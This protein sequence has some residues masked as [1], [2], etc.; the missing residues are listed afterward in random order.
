[1]NYAVLSIMNACIFICGL[2]ISIICKTAEKFCDKISRQISTAI[3]GGS[4]GLQ[5]FS[6]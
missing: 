4:V 3:T 1:M 2:E 6:K 5:G